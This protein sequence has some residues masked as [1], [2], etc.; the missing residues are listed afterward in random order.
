[1][2]K[3][4]YTKALDV[5]AHFKHFK[6]TNV[7]VKQKKNHVYLLYKFIDTVYTDLCNIILH[8]LV[9]TSILNTL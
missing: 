7:N 9:Y 3:F 4:K 8:K 6:A 5:T 1:M 2:L